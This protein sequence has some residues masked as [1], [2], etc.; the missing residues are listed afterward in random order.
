MQCMHS[1]GLFF[2]SRW[3]TWQNN[4][5]LG[6]SLLLE[7]YHFSEARPLRRNEL[8]AE[9]AVFYFLSI[10]LMTD[11]VWMHQARFCQFLSAVFRTATAV[12]QYSNALGGYYL[13]NQMLSQICCHHSS[14]D[15]CG[16]HKATATNCC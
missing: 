10:H 4:R 3:I 9:I 7:I 11:F 2:F 15:M 1:K 6:N 14:L 13:R 5:W 8:S 16:I 12:G